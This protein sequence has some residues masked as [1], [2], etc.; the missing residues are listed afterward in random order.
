MKIKLVISL[1]LLFLLCSIKVKSQ[2]KIESL[3]IENYTISSS[4]SAQK[5]SSAKPN[6]HSI[7]QL[8][9]KPGSGSTI[10]QMILHF[11]LDDRGTTFRPSYDPNTKIAQGHY[12]MSEYDKIYNLLKHTRNQLSASFIDSATNITEISLLAGGKMPLKF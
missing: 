3:V 1:S 7:I 2:T 4:V 10:R 6:F 8:D 11:Y 12:P 9:G 5:S